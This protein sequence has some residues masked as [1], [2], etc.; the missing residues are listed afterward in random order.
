MKNTKNLSTSDWCKK[1][2][3]TFTGEEGKIQGVTNPLSDSPGQADF[4]SG[5]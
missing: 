1:F 3:I 2:E 5:K 4:S